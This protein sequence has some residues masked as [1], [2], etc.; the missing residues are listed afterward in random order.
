MPAAAAFGGNGA[1]SRRALR[2]SAGELT[3]SGL[4]VRV[5]ASALA[6]APAAAMVEIPPAALLANGIRCRNGNVAAPI[7]TKTAA[8]IYFAQP[9]RMD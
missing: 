4:S 9:P 3:D 2:C 6:A 5:A 8:M 7:R 1:P